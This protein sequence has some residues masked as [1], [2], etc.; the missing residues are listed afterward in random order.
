M[1]IEIEGETN[2]Y[3]QLQIG[4]GDEFV[5]ET[6][7]LVC[8]DPMVGI[9]TRF[10]KPG[11]TGWSRLLGA[12]ATMA[13][14]ALSGESVAMLSL[15]SRAMGSGSCR[16][17][18]APPYPG[19]LLSADLK[20]GQGLVCKR[21]AFVGFSGEVDVSFQLI[22]KAAVMMFGTQGLML[23]TLKG[24]G[25]VLF[26]SDGPVIEQW[27]QDRSVLVHP[28]AFVGCSEGMEMSMQS[29]K[30]KTAFFGGEGLFLLCIKGTGSLWLQAASLDA[31]VRRVAGYLLDQR[32]RKDKR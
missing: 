3:A 14:R 24:A 28:E 25:T 26:A 22:K 23:Q 7:S 17:V 20:P 30:V 13:K 27:L 2:Q 4:T 6:G 8:C 9:E 11:A 29:L 10:S 16:A 18:V 15:R 19:R 12:P 21:S 1:K 32:L 31:Q 5:C